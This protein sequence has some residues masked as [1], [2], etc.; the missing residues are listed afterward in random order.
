[1]P[2]V[3]ENVMA[4]CDSRKETNGMK[5]EKRKVQDISYISKKKKFRNFMAM[6]AMFTVM[7]GLGIFGS[8]QYNMKHIVSVVQFDVN[9]SLEIQINKKEEVVKAVGLNA[10]GEE[11]L[12]GMKLSG[13]DIYT[14]TNA[15][16]GSLLK[17]GY[18]DELANSVLLSVEDEDFNRGSMLKE[19]LTGEIYAILE[20]ASVNASIL[21]QYV[22]GKV[23]DS[24]SQ[25]YGISHGKAYLI[26]HILESNENYTFEELSKL[27]VN[28]LNLI[29]SNPKNQVNN[30]ETKGLAAKEAYIGEEKANQIAFSHAGVAESSVYELQV[31]IDYEYGAM[32]YDVEFA[33]GNKEFEYYIHA[34]SGEILEHEVDD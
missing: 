1:M 10:D 28:E 17:H 34:I 5:S 32:V 27:T 15:I 9:P 6:A 33:S 31:E 18:I 8:F 26:E 12:S 7:I 29:I 13:L 16:V 2:D 3:L 14:A 22:D 4:Q 25:Q 30:V 20:G 23:V 19:T 21:S 11:I 24:I